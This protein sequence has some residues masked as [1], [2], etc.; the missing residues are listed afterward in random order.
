MY[1]K[2]LPVITFIP[3]YM[4]K[5][6]KLDCVKALCFHFEF[7]SKKLLFTLNVHRLVGTEV[8]RPEPTASHKKLGNE[9]SQFFLK[10]E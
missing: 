9:G 3:D 4:T 8:I 2:E 7:L 10:C 6:G 1:S 5:I